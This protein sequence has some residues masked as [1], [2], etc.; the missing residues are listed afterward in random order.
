MQACFLASLWHRTKLKTRQNTAGQSTGKAQ[1][2]KH[3]RAKHRQNTAEQSTAE[4]S[5]A[6]QSTAEQ[7]TAEQSTGKAQQAKHRRAKIRQFTAEQSTAGQS[8]G[9]A[10][11]KHTRRQHSRAKHSRQKL[12]VPFFPDCSCRRLKEDSLIHCSI[13]T[14]R[15]LPI[16]FPCRPPPVLFFSQ[17]PMLPAQSD[18]LHTLML[19]H[20]LQQDCRPN[21]S[22]TTE[23]CR[24]NTTAEILAVKKAL[25]Q[26]QSM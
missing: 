3:R 1:Q 9:Q 22:N 16:L 23:H 19:K 24:C 8:A 13:P 2:A 25:Q 12:P 15:L 6:E 20:D 18:L 7:S 10:Q 17:V 5:T 11:A 4:Q 14:V 26:F 21:H